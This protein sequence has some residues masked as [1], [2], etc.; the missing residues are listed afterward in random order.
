MHPF[1]PV[2][3]GVA[4]VVEHLHDVGAAR[5]HAAGHA[6]GHDLA[7]KAQ[8]RRNPR[9]FL[10]AARRVAESRYDLVVD[11]EHAVDPGQ[12]A[13][14]LVEGHRQGCRTPGSAGRLQHDGGDVPVLLQHFVDTLEV[15]RDDFDRIEDGR[16]DAR[17]DGFV[18]GDHGP[19]AHAVVP[20]AEVSLEAQHPGLAGEGPGNA[21]REHAA[22]GPR[23]HEAHAFRAGDQL[24]DQFGPFQLHRMVVAEMKTQIEGV[25]HGPAHFRRRVPQQ[26]RGVAHAIVDV[27]PPVLVPLA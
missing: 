11:Q 15:R 9:V 14:P 21:Q 20:S 2:P 17:R 1:V 26:Q 8:V 3:V 4:G 7:V 19:L 13:K 6:A 27:F 22:L 18:E 5:E 24:L 23:V 12:I 16:R 25:A 10:V